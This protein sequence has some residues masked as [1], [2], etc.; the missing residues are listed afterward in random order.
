[1]VYSWNLSILTEGEWVSLDSVEFNTLYG[2]LYDPSSPLGDENGFR[3]D[4]ID[5]NERIKSN[6][7][8]MARKF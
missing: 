1:M 5:A 2:N 6:Q 4:Y 7:H 3:K 8:A